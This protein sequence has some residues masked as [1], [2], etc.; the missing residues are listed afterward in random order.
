VIAY[1]GDGNLSMKNQEKNKI[2]AGL[3]HE[4]Y[5]IQLMPRCSW[6]KASL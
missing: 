2:T 6:L 1:N 4:A 3:Q 5:S